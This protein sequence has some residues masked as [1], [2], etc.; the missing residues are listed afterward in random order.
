MDLK[1]YQKSSVHGL[2][3]ELFQDWF[4]SYLLALKFR[5]GREKS[6]SLTIRDVSPDVDLTRDVSGSL[7]KEIG[8]A[9]SLMVRCLSDHRLF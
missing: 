5:F 3:R 4:S 9:F 2:L 6:G 1:L 7:Y 8:S